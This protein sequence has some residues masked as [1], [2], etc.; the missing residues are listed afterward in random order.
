MLKLETEMGKKEYINLAAGVLKDMNKQIEE[1]KNE[2]KKK[3]LV[4]TALLRRWGS[5]AVMVLLAGSIFY[6]EVWPKVQRLI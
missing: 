6:R 4:E 5:R 1:I 3:P 2:F